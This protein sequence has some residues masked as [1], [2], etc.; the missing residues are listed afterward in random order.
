[1]SPDRNTRSS[2]VRAEFNRISWE[3]RDEPAKF[4]EPNSS[5]RPFLNNVISRLPGVNETRDLIELLLPENLRDDQT[6]TPPSS[7]LSHPPRGGDSNFS[8]DSTSAHSCPTSLSAL[9][10]MTLAGTPFQGGSFDRT[11]F[12]VTLKLHVSHLVP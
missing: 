7:C 10:P 9:L 5:R 11:E 3:Q 12:H 4:P 2:R 6:M 8:R 1:M